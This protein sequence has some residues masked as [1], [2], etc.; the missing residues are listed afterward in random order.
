[1]GGVLLG[2]CLFLSYGLVL[3]ALPVA[4]VLWGRRAA[5]APAV[6]GAAGVGVAFTLAGFWWFTGYRLV[7][8]RYYAGYGGLRPYGYWVWAD[9]ACLVVCAGPVI[10][11]AL[12]RAVAAV[13]RPV[14]PVVHLPV[15]AA[16]A[17]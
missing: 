6:L 9:L 3:F 15:A 1:L 13:P 11:P 5:A 14:D 8:P 7:R 16:V 17:L 12:R 2:Y 4:V 10:G